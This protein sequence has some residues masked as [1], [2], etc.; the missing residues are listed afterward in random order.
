MKKTFTVT[1]GDAVVRTESEFV[2]NHDPLTNDGPPPWDYRSHCN[3]PTDYDDW[4]TWNRKLDPEIIGAKFDKWLEDQ[5]NAPPLIRVEEVPNGVMMYSPYN[6]D[7]IA[8]IKSAIPR[9]A[10][11]WIPDAKA[12]WISTEHA[13]QGRAIFEIF[14]SETPLDI[15]SEP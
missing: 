4:E 6:E 3:T 9:S 5:Q 2:P 8:L 1:S 12:W 7:Y 14:F 13:E 15:L 10:Y 11:A